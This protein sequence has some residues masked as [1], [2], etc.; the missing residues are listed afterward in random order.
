MGIVSVFSK[1]GTIFLS[2]IATLSSECNELFAIS[3]LNIGFFDLSDLFASLRNPY[4][5]VAAL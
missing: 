1:A 2:Y 4:H 3:L 5:L